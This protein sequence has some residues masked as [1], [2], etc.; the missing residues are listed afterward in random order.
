MNNITFVMLKPDAIEKNLSFKIM[1][2]FKQNGILIDC[3]DVQIADKAKISLHYAEHFEKLG[4][5][6]AHK[7]LDFFVGKTVI[8][9][10]L[11][12][13]ENI[14]DKVREIVGATEPAKAAKGTIRGDFG[15]NDSYEL[16]NKQ[17][18]PV[19]NLIHASDNAF[20]VEREIKI[21]LPDYNFY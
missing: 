10:V 1:N 17:N 13:D 5:D 15:E 14:I 9:V 7:M 16:S 19:K 12:S 11:R 4:N 20:N 6:F 21:W 18:R 8:P 2:Y 3:F